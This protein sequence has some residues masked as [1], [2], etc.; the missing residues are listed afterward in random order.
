GVEFGPERAVALLD[1]AGGAVDAEADGNEPVLAAGFEEGVPE[2]QPG[3]HRHVELP[4]EVA[5]LGDARGEHLQRADL[6][7]PAG[8]EP[9]A[10]LGDIGGGGTA[11]D[12]AGPGSPQTDRRPRAREVGDLGAGLGQTVGEPLEVD[13]AVSGAGDDAEAVVGQP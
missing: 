2:P 13:H 1:P 12:V 11:E 7:G 8:G 10:L 4:A 6:D 9:E 3:F 5:D